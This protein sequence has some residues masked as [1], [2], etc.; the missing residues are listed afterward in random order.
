MLSAHPVTGF[1]FGSEGS[2]TDAP[3]KP[4]TWPD[5]DHGLV[6]GPCKVLVNYMHSKYGGKCANYC[7]SI[8]LTCEGAWEELH[9]TCGV[10]YTGGCHRN[11]G[12]T[13]D[14]ICQCSTGK[15][16]I[17]KP[18]SS[19]LIPTQPKGVG[20]CVAQ[21]A[22]EQCVLTR[23]ADILNG[24]ECL[25]DR[26]CVAASSCLKST[27]GP[28][29]IAH[30]PVECT[31]MQCARPCL[32]Q[33]QSSPGIASLA[34][35]T[36]GCLPERAQ[37][38]TVPTQIHLAHGHSSATQMTVSWMTAA[39]TPTV[40]LFDTLLDFSSPH[41]ALGC[42]GKCGTTAARAA[43]LQALRV[44]HTA[45]RALPPTRQL[46]GSSTTYSF[47]G[48]VHHG[49][50]FAKTQ[51]TYTSGHIHHAMLTGLL[52]GTRYYYV[53]G[54]A[55]SWS[56]VR[57]FVTLPTTSASSSLTIAVVGDLG[58]THDSATVV[59]HLLDRQQGYQTVMHVGDLSYADSLQARWDSYS[60]MVQ[61]VAATLGW[62]SCPGN[63]EIET[64]HNGAKFTA[65]DAR[66]PMPFK[67]SKSSSNHWWSYDA[68]PAHVIALNSY[69]ST[70]EGGEQYKW[71]VQDLDAID[72]GRTPWLI[73]MFHAPF[74]N[75]NF[76]HH[77]EM[78]A[79]IM[80]DS[81]E[82]LLYAAGTDLVLSGHVHAYE[83]MHPTYN[84]VTNNNGPT[85]I[86]I[87]DG[88]N[89][90]GPARRWRN[91]LRDQAHPVWS[92]F[93]SPYFGHGK[94]VL[95]NCSHAAWTWHR[96]IDEERVVTDKI[97]LA[98]RAF[99]RAPKGFACGSASGS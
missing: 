22:C 41:A 33:Q 13:S 86:N 39:S 61:P 66:F 29:H 98:T 14:A 11:F 84:N 77:N 46:Q 20:N 55:A 42:V 17:P 88:G 65:Y 21:A 18:S 44:T 76:A 48:H 52:P 70:Y 45:M 28:W 89:R 92:A 79:L 90:E 80:R 68:G 82:E 72:R 8:G 75:S 19:S 96:V 99:R 95:K 25:D 97:W 23:C 3:C 26:S 9:D 4:A 27:I 91:G 43:L 71:L 53:V 63:H 15:A 31:A 93:R 47:R 87:G 54:G 74:Y 60:R 83:R 58:Q 49:G 38:A 30:T 12:R 57:S 81:M 69:D 6:C 85:Y 62:M 67:G 73:V 78:Q 40:V 24:D 50:N 2:A 64:Q 1:G 56:V 32:A 5:R 37:A 59:Q 7:S 36:A 94:L 34:T 51:G 10:K 16:K 35:C